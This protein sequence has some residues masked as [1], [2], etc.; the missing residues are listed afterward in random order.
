[1]KKIK[2]RIILGMVTGILSG[3]PP[4]VL[5][6]LERR[7]GLTDLSYAKLSAK[8]F[9][10]ANKTGTS[11]GKLLAMLINCING[12]MAGISITYLISL[13]GRDKSVIKGI[14]CGAVFWILINGLFSNF[15]LKIKSQK[16]LTPIL[17]LLNHVLAAGLNGFLVS[18]L[19]DDSLFPD[20][21]MKKQD[22]IPVVNT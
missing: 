21:D 12:A 19:G 15:G 5:D 8:L 2:D 7:L 1:M 20:N 17:S 22:K 6:A 3:G 16:P 10:P 11:Q 18:K 14:G 9:I 4:Q 13:T